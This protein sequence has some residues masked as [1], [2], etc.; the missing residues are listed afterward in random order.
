MGQV[1]AIM[2]TSGGKKPPRHQKSMA[3]QKVPDRLQRSKLFTHLHHVG[4]LG[5]YL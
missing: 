1:E 5:E 3:L 2:Q 4:N